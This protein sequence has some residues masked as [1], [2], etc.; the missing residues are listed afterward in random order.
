ML[1][2]F[3]SKNRDIQ[4]LV[5][6][7]TE[8]TSGITNES[9]IG[10]HEIAN[11]KDFIQE[12]TYNHYMSALG[13]T[14][15]NSVMAGFLAEDASIAAQMFLN[16]LA[17]SAEMR[18]LTE[19]TAVPSLNTLTASIAVTQRVP[20]EATLHRM[21]DT[22]SLDKATVEIED[23][24]PMVKAPNQDPE[25]LIDAFAPGRAD[26]FVDKTEMVLTDLMTNGIAPGNAC[27]NTD[28]CN[29]LDPLLRINR[30]M[31]VDHI[32]LA[33]G[34][35]LS[36]V[37]LQMKKGS[38]PY[39]DAKTSVMEVVYEAVNTNGVVT[40]ELDVSAKVDFERGILEY[41]RADEEVGKVY[42]YATMSHAEHTHPIQTMFRNNFQ[43][44]TVPTRPHI[45]VSLPQEVKTDI[46]NSIQHFADNDIITAMT[47]QISV[48]SSR[49]EDQRL[50]KGLTGGHMFE[51][52]FNFEPPANFNYG[53]LEWLKREFIPFMDQIATK[54]KCEYNLDDCHFRVAVSPYILKILDTEHVV[55]KAMTEDTK[56]SGI[57]NYSIGVKTSTSQ[58]Y[59][60]SSQMIGASEGLIALLPNNFKNSPVKTYNYFKYSSFLTDQIRRSD[61]P[62]QSAIVYTERNLPIVFT[63]VATK[64]SITN[65]P[66]TIETGDRWYVK[67][68]GATG[69]IH[70]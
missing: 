16:T 5:K 37:T 43:Q 59:F 39:F 9:V 65:M 53:N 26:L 15:E 28:L 13:I 46:S 19:A 25:D 44:F 21:Y 50:Y 54:M 41:L 33:T 64:L 32:D 20:Y 6:E 55:N 56:A 63:P 34:T 4:A 62:R 57:I 42:F 58:F 29:G 31:R 40:A 23:V 14:D 2:L 10:E 69:T 18:S 66:I 38:V 47:E 27:K 11:T 48:I 35:T 67:R 17:E 8:S 45:E 51:A 60:I 3:D 22:R 68:A 52:L 49:M 1:S 36:N 61:N 24:I 30:D 12:T 70:G 7:L